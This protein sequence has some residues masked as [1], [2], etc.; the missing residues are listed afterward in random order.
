MR[1]RLAILTTAIGVAIALAIPAGAVE[2]HAPHQNMT[3]DECEG[4]VLLH[5]VNNQYTE[6]YRGTITVD[7]G[8]APIVQ[9]ADKWNRGTQHFNVT[10]GADDTL[11]TASTDL[12]GKLV[13]SDYSCDTGKKDP[14]KST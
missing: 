12:S 4:P 13:L 2:L 6:N 1:G 9:P 7:A 3:F 14:K 10:I 11:I 8:G 5:F